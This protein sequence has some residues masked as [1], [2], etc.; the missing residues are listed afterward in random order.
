M[1]PPL[2]KSSPYAAASLLCALGVIG[3]CVMWV[4]LV[5]TGGPLSKRI[6]SGGVFLLMMAGAYVL[7]IGGCVLILGGLASSVISL[8]RKE[9]HTGVALLGLILSIGPTLLVLLL[10]AIF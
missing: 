10:I 7:A 5:E 2:F 3:L 9:R 6:G 8:R 1:K 4:G